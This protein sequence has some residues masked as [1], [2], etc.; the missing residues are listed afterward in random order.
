[1]KRI[2]ILL[3]VLSAISLVLEL[4]PNGVVLLFGNPEGEPW[5]QT[6]SYFSLVPYG[7]ANFGPLIA[8]IL[9]I[10]L[11]VLTGIGLFRLTNGLQKGIRI[12]SLLATVASISPALLG[13]TITPVG[14][15]AT[16]F[17]AGVFALCCVQES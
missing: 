9:T 11:V 10:I 3:F 5:R 1:M 7:Y 14:V 15:A 13:M 6:Y 4:L 12:L 2:K 16:V 17:L 8:G